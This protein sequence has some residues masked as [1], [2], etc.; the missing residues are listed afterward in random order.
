[1]AANIAVT[2]A[3]SQLSLGP[4][5]IIGDPAGSDFFILEYFKMSKLQGPVCEII[6]LQCNVCLSVCGEPVYKNITLSA[7]SSILF[8]PFHGF[9]MHLQIAM[10]QMTSDIQSVNATRADKQ[11]ADANGCVNT[12]LATI[13][14]HNNNDNAT[15][16]VQMESHLYNSAIAMTNVNATSDLRGRPNLKT[17][18]QCHLAPYSD[19]G[20]EHGTVKRAMVKT[21]R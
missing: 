8:E 19:N 16:R 11:S 18:R 6:F 14:Q 9:Q 17:I 5:F 1:M 7:S 20:S 21:W 4:H 10:E 13:Q 2:V 3:S 15:G 12:R